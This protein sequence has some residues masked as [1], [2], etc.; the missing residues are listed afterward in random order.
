MLILANRHFINIKLRYIGA[1]C[2]HRNMVII[3]RSAMAL[4]LNANV[5]ECTLTFSTQ[6]TKTYLCFHKDRI[7]MQ[8]MERH[9]LTSQ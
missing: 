7:L 1:V 6:E 8:L 3:T 2:K 9:P 4:S 5:Q